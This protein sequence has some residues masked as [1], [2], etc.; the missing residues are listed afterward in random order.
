MRLLYVIDSLAPG[1]AETSLLEMAPYLTAERIDL[2]VL[3]LGARLDLAGGLEDAGAVVHRHGP[4]HGR[5]H[6]LRTAL[7][8]I[9]RVHPA[10]VHT[11]LFEADIAGRSAARLLN[12]PSSTSIVSDSYSAAHYA[13]VQPVKLHAARALDSITAQSAHAFHAISAAIARTVPPRLR[14]SSGKVTVVPRARDPRNY[15]FTPPGT[16]VAVRRELGIAPQVPV[17]LGVGRLEPP[18][19]FQ[20]LLRALPAVHAQHPDVVTLIAGAEGMSSKSLRTEAE[21]LRMDVRFLGHRTDIAALLSAADVL[22]SPS[23]REGFGGVLIEAM[24]VGCP[25][26][27]SSIATSLEVLAAAEPAALISSRG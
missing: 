19:G 22:C 4:P 9:R 10:L 16:R 13:E 2:H 20:H 15:P 3:P 18:K 8:V 11:T 12:V 23:E 27:A 21:Q 26:V 6:N 14:I 5:A 24:A 17:I 7:H 1:G 25:I